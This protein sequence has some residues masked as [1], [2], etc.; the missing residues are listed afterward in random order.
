MHP[1]RDQRRPA[2]SPSGGFTLFEMLVVLA[3]IAVAMAVTWP[4]LQRM[5]NRQQLIQGAELARIRLLAARVHSVDHG[6]PYQFRFEPGGQ[7]Y[8]VLHGDELGETPLAVGGGTVKLPI[9]AGKLPGKAKFNRLE[10]GTTGGGMIPETRFSP[11]PDAHDLA[12]VEWSP[13]IVFQPDG[14]SL[15][16]MITLTEPD[17][18]ITI[19]L[20]LRGLTGGV[21]IN[22]R[23]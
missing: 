13:P 8:C 7:R 15:D 6:V 20:M 17:S 22:R 23:Q 12:I 1:L 10:I 11:L 16:Q 19:E 14:S 3:L 21:T 2:E 5:S 18:G 9:S 4:A